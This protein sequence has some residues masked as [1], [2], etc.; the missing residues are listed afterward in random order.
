MGWRFAQLSDAHLGSK[1]PGLADEVQ[2]AMRSAMRDSIIAG[3]KLAREKDCQAVLVPGDLFDAKAQDASAQLIWFYEAVADLPS[4]QFYIAPGEA[5]AFAASSPY[6]LVRPPSNV[7]LFV[8]SE[9]ETVE[10]NGTTITGRALRGGE[11]AVQV[12][13]ST[14]PKP[15]MD[16][17]SVLLL[18]GTLQ[19]ADD[20][21]ERRLP[22]MQFSQRDLYEAQYTYTAMGHLHAHIELQRRKGKAMA[23]YAGVPQ[24]LSFEELGPGG[25]IIG[26]LDPDGAELS[27]HQTNRYHWS[28]RVVDFPPLY[29]ENYKQQLAAAF[30]AISQAVAAEDIIKLVCSGEL[31]I[32]RRAELDQLLETVAKS[33]FCFEAD[34]TPLRWFNGPDQTELPRESLL[35]EFMNRCSAEAARPGADPKMYELV[36]RLGWRLFNGLGLPAELSQ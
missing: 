33:A 24:C 25:I 26:S 6:S 12:D 16:R 9:W 31:A 22:F 17:L 21:K 14:V 15:R 23:A 7:F 8:N 18:H 4:L 5:D 36:R 19:G 34:V 2:T 29:S 35:A 32:S 11:G 1:L 10:I 30:Q 28:K 20:G 13:W 3:L 27:F